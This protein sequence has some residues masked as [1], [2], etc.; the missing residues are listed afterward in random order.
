[1]IY[2]YINAYPFYVFIIRGFFKNPASSAW[3]MESSA[4]CGSSLTSP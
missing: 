3:N 1:M 2:L 4:L